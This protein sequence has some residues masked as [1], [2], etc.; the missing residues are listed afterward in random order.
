M[1]PGASGPTSLAPLTGAGGIRLFWQLYER[2]TNTVAVL[3]FTAMI[4]VTSLGVFFRYVLNAPLHWTEESDRYLFIWLTW[5]GASITMRYR[6]H[7]A[8]DILVRQFDPRRRLWFALGAQSCVLAFLAVVFYASLPVLEVTSRT[9]TVATDV[10][11]SWVYMAVPVGCTLIAIETLRIMAETW[12][13]IR[14]EPQA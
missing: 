13:R 2:L 3:L 4:V 11:T 9:R 1:H 5:V 10:P 12:R 6:A 7:I 14:E 8:V